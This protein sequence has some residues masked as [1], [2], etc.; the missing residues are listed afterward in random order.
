MKIKYL[1]FDFDG[2]IS[3]SRKVVHKTFVH[4]LNNLDFRFSKLKLKKIMGIKTNEVLKELG[5]KDEYLEKIK[6]NFYSAISR[7]DLND[8][9][10]SVNIN[11]LKDLKKKGIRLII[12]SNSDSIFL[13][14]S[15]KH[16]GLTNLFYEI[17]GGDSFTTKDKI[18]KKLMKKYKL[19][20]EN[21]FYI[22]DR[23]SDIEFGHKAGFNAIAIYNK[24]SWSTKKEILDKKPEYIIHDL[25]DLKKII[26]NNKAGNKTRIHKQY[27]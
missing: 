6:K 8:L 17:Y 20:K 27:N 7:S 2:T 22:G 21:A 9:R 11:P 16:L 10:L 24:S 13:K 3:D 15:I 23:F 1:F 14:K 19:K 18:L 12:I 25:S 4:V 26:E 5:I